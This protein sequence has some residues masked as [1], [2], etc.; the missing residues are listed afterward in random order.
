MKVFVTGGSGFIGSRVV[1]ILLE[2]QFDVMNYDLK[3]P[4]F[5]RHAR[6]WRPGDVLDF[7]ALSAAMV[8]F[9]P[10]MVIHLA[11]KAEIYEF[12]W[13]DFASIHQGTENLLKA[14]E[15]YGKLD[16]LLNV[17]TQLVIAPGYQPRSLL[18]FEP[19]TMYG[20]AKAY[21]ESLLFQWRS[22]VHWV[23]VRPANVWGP[24]HPSFA[25]AIWKYIG[26][27]AYLHPDTREP[28]MRSYGYVRNTAEQIVAL[29]LHDPKQD[30]YRQVFYAA[31]SVMDSAI[32]VDAFAQGLC[33]KPSR[34][35]PSP[36]L[37][38]MGLVGD[39]SA[40]AGKRLPMDS[41]RAMRMTQSYPVPLQPTFDLIGPPQVGFDQGL[42]ESLEWL[43]SLKKAG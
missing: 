11:A 21:A 7:P 36:V 32:W 31:D 27:R 26:N 41:G 28:V 38:A 20:E 35:I 19:Y 9:E 22:P 4:T 5:E 24:N 1:D 39:I 13:S 30:T 16:R 8:E 42:A 33:G 12:E 25:G 2:K 18:D 29:A 6:H 10:Q 14:I 43:S 23:T 37:K 34:R 15:Q 17:S 40:K 3:T